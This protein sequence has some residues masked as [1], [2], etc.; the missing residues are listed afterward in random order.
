MLR[1]N[2]FSRI[3]ASLARCVLEIP[4]VRYYGEFGIVAPL[5]IAGEELASYTELN[6]LLGVQL[7]GL[8]FESGDTAELLGPKYHLSVRNPRRIL[9]LPLPAGRRAGVVE[10]VG[11]MSRTRSA[12]IAT[13]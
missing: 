4:P 6:N 9:V 11:E 5:G 3:I 1:N 12:S 2:C 13:M 7:R 8:K 10:Q